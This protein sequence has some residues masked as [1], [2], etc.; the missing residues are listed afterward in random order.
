MEDILDDFAENE[1]FEDA[2]FVEV[3]IPVIPDSRGSLAYIQYPET[4][5]SRIKSVRW[6]TVKDADA[7]IGPYVVTAENEFFVALR[8]GCYISV[9]NES[10]DVAISELLPLNSPAYGAT[11]KKGQTVELMDFKPNTILLIIS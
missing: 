6:I 2:Q 9:V 4:L 10:E 8:G 11:V 1:I 3:D 5:D 7:H